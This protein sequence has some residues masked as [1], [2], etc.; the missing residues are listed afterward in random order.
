MSAELEKKKIAVTSD[1]RLFAL[2]WTPLNLKKCLLPVL[3]WSLKSASN[4]AHRA[5]DMVRNPLQMRGTFF[6]HLV[7]SLDPLSGP[8]PA[9]ARD[10]LT[11]PAVV[12][13]VA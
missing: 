8:E 2:T 5:D 4:A 6:S 12:G 10:A 11:K 9:R 3:P 13:F 7:P 1:S